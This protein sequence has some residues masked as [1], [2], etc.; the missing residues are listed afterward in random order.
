MAI[1]VY[2]LNSKLKF[3]FKQVCVVKSALADIHVFYSKVCIC[4]KILYV[5]FIASLLFVYLTIFSYTFNSF[6]F[7]A[8]IIPQT[9]FHSKI[10]YACIK[11]VVFSP[12]CVY[13]SQS[14][15]NKQ[16]L[17]ILAK[18]NFLELLKISYFVTLNT[19]LHIFHFS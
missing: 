8:D 18:I 14:I 12:F 6:H 2:Y 4:L 17:T 5:F 16:S 13:P 15:T 1:F 10:I 9:F 19:I 7:I 3:V 11:Y